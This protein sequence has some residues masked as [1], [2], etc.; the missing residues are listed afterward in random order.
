MDLYCTSKR[1]AGHGRPW[2]VEPAGDGVQLLIRRGGFP[3]AYVRTI[4]E[5]LAIIT[6]GKES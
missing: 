3:V 4:P 6:E 5:V 1:A 2:H